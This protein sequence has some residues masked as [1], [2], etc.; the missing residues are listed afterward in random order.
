MH[1]QT[2]PDKLLDAQGR[3]YFLWDCEL[4]LEQFLRELASPEPTRRAYMLAKLMRQ[5]KPED[6]FY[7]VNLR[8]LQQSW[9]LVEKHLGA[10]RPFWAWLLERW[11]EEPVRAD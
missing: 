1:C 11:R 9:T 4:T 2:P 6:V 10:S 7:F 5:A 8:T 3:P